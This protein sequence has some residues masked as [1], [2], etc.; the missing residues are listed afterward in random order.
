MITREFYSLS[1]VEKL[2]GIPSR[3]LYYLAY[4]GEIKLGA[5]F[6][7]RSKT[8]TFKS[9][10]YIRNKDE[11]NHWLISARSNINGDRHIS[12]GSYIEVISDSILFDGE[13]CYF[14][15]YLKGY[16]NFDEKHIFII[17]DASG[18]EEEWPAYFSPDIA[19]NEDC[20]FIKAIPIYEDDIDYMIN[21]TADLSGRDFDKLKRKYF[22]NSET[23]SAQSLSQQER[24]AKPRV[25]I[26][27]AV[28]SIMRSDMSYLNCTVTKLTDALFDRAHIYWPEEKSPPLEYETIKKLISDSLKFGS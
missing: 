13:G 12:G 28:I 8:Y 21:G 23:K 17:Y 6:D 20:N 25:E 5:I 14:Y 16:W 4:K 18:D 22:K 26:L 1:D 15:A 11:F 7:E 19:Q 2:L 9:K 10:V 3:D 27:Q 24:R